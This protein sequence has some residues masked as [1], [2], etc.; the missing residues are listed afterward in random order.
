MPGNSERRTA[1]RR[2]VNFKVQHRDPRTQKPV[3]DFAK[4][5][6]S[7]GL[8]L[9]TKR[10]RAIGSVIEVSFPID[11]LTHRIRPVRLTCTVTRTTPDGLGVNFRVEDPAVAATLKQ[12]LGT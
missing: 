9:R 11:D 10:T 1:L 5:L 2:T 3:C 7:T 12:L 8:F 4:D 6:S